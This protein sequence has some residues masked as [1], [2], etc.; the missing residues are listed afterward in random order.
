MSNTRTLR[1][2]IFGDGKSA[3]KALSDSSDGLK[4]VSKSSDSAGSS[5]DK[6]T[7]KFDLF[8]MRAK[9]AADQA[10]KSLKAVRLKD[11][12]NEIARV[13]KRIEDLRVGFTKTKNVD[14]FGQIRK[15][16]STL[17]NLQRVRDGI[18]EIGEGASKVEGALSAVGN[19]IGS[20][21]SNATGIFSKTIGEAIQASGP[22][23]QTAIAGIAITALASVA[24]LVGGALAG[25]VAGGVGIGGIIGGIVIASRSPEVQ[26]AAQGTADIFKSFL[27]S[28]GQSFVTPVRNALGIVQKLIISQQSRFSQIFSNLSKYVVPLTKGVSG[29]FENMLPG[30]N[31][32]SS[33]LDPIMTE[34]E[35]W[36]PRLGDLFKEIFGY[37][38]ENAD[39]AAAALHDIVSVIIF[40]V[41]MVAQWIVTMA[42]L[43]GWIKKVG[44]AFSGAWGA[45]QHLF[46][47]DGDGGRRGG[48]GAFADDMDTAGDASVYLSDSLED[49]AGSATAANTAISLLDTTLGAFANA[50]IA[51]EQAASQMHS[52]I[53]TATEKIKDN[54]KQ[55]DTTR[56]KYWENRD[57]LVA[58]ATA[59][60]QQAQ[61][62]LD[63]GGSMNEAQHKSEQARAAFVRLATKALGSASAAKQLADQLFNMPSAN[64]T[65]TVHAEQANNAIIGINSNLSSLD[66]KQ[67]NTYINTVV[68]Y[69]Q[70]S[71]DQRGGEPHAS[72]GYIAGPGT[73]TSDDIPAML[74]NGEYVVKASAVR[75]YGVGFL[76][77][78]NAGKY[79]RGGLVR[80]FA[81]GGKATKKKEPTAADKLGPWL[82]D[83]NVARVLALGSVNALDDYTDKILDAVTGK[84]D[85]SAKKQLKVLSNYAK[86]RE[87]LAD[88]LEAA[89]DKLSDALRAKSDYRSQV[90][91]SAIAAGDITSGNDE[92]TNSSLIIARLRAQVQKTK[93]FRVYLQKL[94]KMGINRTLYEQIANAGVDGGY[95]TAKALVEGGLPAIK[96]VNSLGTQ[97]EN[98]ATG[99][100][101][102]TSTRLYQAGVNAAQGLVKG[103]EAQEAALNKVATKLANT[104][105]SQL[106]RELKIKSPSRVMADKIG[107]WLPRGI[108]KGVDEEAPVVARSLRRA[109]STRGLADGQLTAAPYRGQVNVYV[110]AEGHITTE[111]RLAE[112]IAPSVRDAIARRGKNNGGRTG[113]GIK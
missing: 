112:V 37:L 111:K 91:G 22:V 47:A 80:R 35:S 83:P 34:I 78:V 27:G 92:V 15:S 32:L 26:R 102:D 87:A 24:S 52:A 17:R 104:L 6:T 20:F 59:A 14:I 85:A 49:A 66:G 41:R 53:A 81:K 58:I 33:K 31:Y 108:A 25:A 50:N 45:L 8:G 109:V 67:V 90:R 51:A 75:K 10:A 98:A 56:A 11:L 94:Q 38:A 73:G 86:K 1:L 28:A 107:K 103:L 57:A 105:V 71:L 76:D 43:W 72:G 12:D 23:V 65:I 69:K 19:A 101:N 82:R 44:G 7:R 2:R 96:Q 46:G 29:F 99:L 95:A 74:S 64:P 68:T 89:R 13:T 9:R 54:G 30:L 84:L 93:D 55:T 79:A 61:A 70:R 110:T 77:R 60:N 48:A 4:E 106:K 42:S 18:D 113:L 100:G 88:R 36:G 40:I 5:L 21:A 39:D 97:L 62:V 16:E 63:A 3:K